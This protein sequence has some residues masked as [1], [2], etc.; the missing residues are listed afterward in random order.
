MRRIILLAVLV[1]FCV[2]FIPESVCWSK[3]YSY[4]SK[5]KE[6]DCRYCSWVPTGDPWECCG[7]SYLDFE[8]KHFSPWDDYAAR[9]TFRLSLT[10]YYL[11]SFIQGRLRVYSADSLERILPDKGRGIIRTG[12]TIGGIDDDGFEFWVNFAGDY[13]I[14]RQKFLN[15]T[16]LTQNLRWDF[17]IDDRQARFTES[18]EYKSGKGPMITPTISLLAQTKLFR[19]FLPPA[20]VTSWIGFSYSYSVWYLG[21]YDDPPKPDK[22]NFYSHGGLIMLFEH[23]SGPWIEVFLGKGSKTI[24]RGDSISNL[25]AGMKIEIRFTETSRRSR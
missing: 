18:L 10:N 12:F 15:G 20:F 11:E 5:N 9:G 24:G 14:S 4:G 8:A 7:W 21:Y 13:W 19:S 6:K 16:V 23:Q 25:I 17:P 3:G 2:I 1:C 22:Y